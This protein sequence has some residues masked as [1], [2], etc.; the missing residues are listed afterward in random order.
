MDQSF[1][2]SLVHFSSHHRRL[3]AD[4]DDR[5]VGI[6]PHQCRHHLAVHHAQPRD[7]MHPATWIDHR[8]AC[9]PG[10]SARAAP[11]PRARPACRWPG[12]GREGIVEPMPGGLVHD[13]QQH[14]AG[15]AVRQAGGTAQH[16]LRHRPVVPLLPAARPQ[17]RHGIG[18]ARLRPRWQCHAAKPRQQQ[19]PPRPGHTDSAPPIILSRHC[20]AVAAPDRGRQWRFRHSR[21]ARTGS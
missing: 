7:A 20:R 10:Q 4:H 14:I 16:I 13:H 3:L 2:P 15:R 19:P 5:D 17:M 18:L 9:R 6:C 1:S 8:A 11:P 12:P 21:N